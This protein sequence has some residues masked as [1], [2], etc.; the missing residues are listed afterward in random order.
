MFC[1]IGERCREGEELYHD[2][3][4]AGV[5]P[6]MVMMYGQM[7]EPPAPASAWAWRP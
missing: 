6:H 1:G 3:K 5:L 2:M 7:N 4:A